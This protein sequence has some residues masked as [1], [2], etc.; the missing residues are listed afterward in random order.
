MA[1]D[2]QESDQLPRFWDHKPFWCQPWTIVL[3]GIG[4]V[5]GSWGL[6]ARWWITAPLALLVLAWWWL[7]LILVPEA[8]QRQTEAERVVRPSE[9]PQNSGLSG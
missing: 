8:Y 9:D 2:Q 4:A 3:S 6:L 1:V 5:A 7:F